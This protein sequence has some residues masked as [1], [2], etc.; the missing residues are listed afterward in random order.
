MLATFFFLAADLIQRT[1]VV[2]VIKAW[3]GLRDRV[4][5]CWVRIVNSGI[6]GLVV[7]IA[8][9]RVDLG[10]RI[11]ANPGILIVM[12]HQSL[13]DIPVAIACVEGG[14]PKIVARERYCKGYPLI[15]HMIRL[16]AHP[17]VRPGEHTTV[18]LEALK[19]T[20]KEAERPVVIYPEGSRTRDGEIRRFKT[21]GL[22]AILSARPWSV[23]LLVADG[24]CESAGLRGFVKNISSSVIKTETDGP[25]SFDSEKGDLDAFIASM[26]QR[27]IRKLAQM[28][29]PA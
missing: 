14:Y 18:Q 4:L 10:A 6:M 12:N 13:L 20:V 2:V 28:R 11:P 1:L 5:T 26:E 23:Y 17:T 27:M 21:A 9:A 15:S 7:H 19:R 3:P 29:A 22:K 25:F 8:G 24:M 16:Y